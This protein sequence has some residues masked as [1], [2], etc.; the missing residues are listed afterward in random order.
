MP[1]FEDYEQKYAKTIFLIEVDRIKPNPM[2]PRR[3]FDNET[4]SNLAESIRQYGILQPLV[5]TRKE[6]EVPTGT[7]VEYEL[8]SGERRL[9][10]SRLAGL[11]Q[12]P[13]IIRDEKNDKIKLE[14]AI[15]ENLQREDLNPMERAFAFKKLA[16]EFDLRHHEIGA[17]VGKSRVFVS[18]TVRLLSLPEI[19]QQAVQRGDIYEGHCR[20]LLML[21][22]RKEEQMKLFQEMLDRKMSVRE[23]ERISRTIAVER[24]RKVEPPKDPEVEDIAKKL[25][26]TLGTRVQIETRGERGRISI[27]FF[28]REELAAF[29]KKMTE[30][31]SIAEDQQDKNLSTEEV[32]INEDIASGFSL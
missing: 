1:N 4:L 24:A 14:L 18:N 16:E 30:D 27:D 2:Q 6:V 3:E 23:A 8:I 13:V 28:S 5:V 25:S 29:L 26:D 21:V 15:I 12:V 31:L 11:S 9:R 32:T 20:P 7:Q 17:R 19:M 10:A 22:D